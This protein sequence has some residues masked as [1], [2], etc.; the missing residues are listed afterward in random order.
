MES[1]D[2]FVGGMM[3]SPADDDDDVLC[4][5]QVEAS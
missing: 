5:Y 4:E 3:M 1:S 2:R